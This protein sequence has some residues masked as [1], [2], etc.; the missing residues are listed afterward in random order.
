MYGILIENNRIL[1]HK[2]PD[3]EEF[4]VPGGAVEIE[5]E[6]E[7]ALVREFKEETGITV[8]IKRQLLAIED[9]FTFQGEDAH[10]VLVFYLV[11]RD[12]GK[13]QVPIEKT[14]ESSSIHFIPLDEIKEAKIQRV[15]RKFLDAVGDESEI[16]WSDRKSNFSPDD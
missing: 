2:N 12:S 6:M 7:D 1:M 14:D 16:H 13:K 15:F 3:I 9:F 4:C 11:K 8:S 10:S 5:E